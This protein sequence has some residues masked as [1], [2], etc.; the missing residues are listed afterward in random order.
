M[1]YQGGPNIIISILKSGRRRQKG[2]S[3]R[4]IWLYKDGKSNVMLLALKMLGDHY[5]RNVA[6]IL[7]RVRTE[8][9]S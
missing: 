4:E 6:G 7:K 5:S 1:E 2:E 8:M 3:K 9:C